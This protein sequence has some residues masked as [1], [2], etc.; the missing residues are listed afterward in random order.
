[1]GKGGQDFGKRDKSEGPTLSADRDVFPAWSKEIQECEKHFG[2]NRKFG[3][4]SEDVA[5]RR[6]EY[7]WNELEKHEGQSIW[8]LVL[9]QFNDTLV[10]I[11]LAVAVISFVLV[12]LDREEGGEKEIT[13][14][15]EPRVIFLILIV[16]L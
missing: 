13:T 9:E 6:E 3:L 2:V 14:F 8:S 12:W 16:S 4:K 15:V 7:G 1:M 10:R 11:L 5:K